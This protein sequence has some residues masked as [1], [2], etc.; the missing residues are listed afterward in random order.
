MDI[1]IRRIVE[2]IHKILKWIKPIFLGCFNK[3]EHDGAGLH[4]ARNVCEQKILRS[5]TKG[6]MLLTALLMLISN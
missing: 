2:N 6:F 1:P 5:M 4:T 3:A